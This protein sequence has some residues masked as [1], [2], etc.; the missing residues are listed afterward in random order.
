M[1]VHCITMM[2]N[3]SCWLQSG[4]ELGWEKNC[5]YV[6]S[7]LFYKM[8][9]LVCSLQALSSGRVKAKSALLM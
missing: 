5:L 2:L 7:S 6:N 9:A 3:L 1:L 8:Y 4:N